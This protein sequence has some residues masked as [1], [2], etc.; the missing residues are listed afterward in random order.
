VDQHGAC[1]DELFDVDGFEMPQQALGPADRDLLVERARL[2]REIVEAARIMAAP[3]LL[4]T[5]GWTSASHHIAGALVVT[6][7]VVA[8]GEIL[9][10]VRLLNLPL[11]V[12]LIVAAWVLPG[13]TALSP[14]LD[15]AAGAAIVACSIRRGHIDRDFGAWNRVLI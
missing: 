5:S 7:S 12:W 13:A 14:W 1:V 6:W 10:P 2:A 15:S 3:A 4:G 11:G 9:R 8:F